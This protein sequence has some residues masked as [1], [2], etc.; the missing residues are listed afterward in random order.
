[1]SLLNDWRKSATFAHTAPLLL[2][3]AISAL[4]APFKTENSALP[5][6]QQAPEHWLYPLQILAVGALLFWCRA[7]YTLRPWR[8]MGLAVLLGVAGIAVWVLP[9][10]LYLAWHSAG[11]TEPAWWEWLGI[12]ERTQGFT[13]T[14]FPEHSSAYW[15]TVLLRFARMVLIVPLVEELFWR[16]FLMRYLQAGE[17][18]FTRVPFGKHSW[19]AYAVVTLAVTFIHSTE[20]WAAAF[21]WGS[22][23]YLLAVKTRSLGACVLM[24]AVGNLVLG[25]YIMKTQ[26]WGFW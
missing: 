9:A 15:L 21:I 11:A 4:V 16:S 5:W 12:V 10:Q 2:F 26:Q 19:V 25:L 17:K 23:M 8:G 18:L 14:L 3:M 6:Y 1:M 7:H 20:D 13:P 22:L 24:H